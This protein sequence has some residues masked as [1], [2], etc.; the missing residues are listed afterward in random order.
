[1][2]SFHGL[3]MWGIGY[4]IYK[5]RFI[6]WHYTKPE[7][8]IIFFLA[9]LS[10]LYATL[11]Y[12][13]K[14]KAIVTNI[15]SNLKFERQ[16]VLFYYFCHAIGFYAAYKFIKDFSVG[17]GGFENFLVAMFLENQGYMIRELYE[18]INTSATQI[19]YFGW[20]AVCIT[21]YMI[22][23]KSIGKFTGILL[24]ILQFFPNLLYVDRTRPVWL[25]FCTFISYFPLNNNLSLKKII[26][27]ISLVLIGGPLLFVLLALASG[28]GWNYDDQSNIYHDLVLYF[29]GSFAYFNRIYDEIDIYNQPK[30]L[31]YP[32][33]KITSSINLTDQPPSQIL[34][35][36]SLPE[37]ANVGTFLEPFYS[38]GGILYTLIGI[39]IHALLLN[40]INYFFLKQRT[41]FFMFLSSNICFI[42]FIAFFT[43]KIASTPIWLFCFI[44][45]IYTFFEKKI[46]HV[47]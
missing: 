35:F 36:Y 16:P 11:L 21:P 39:L 13:N 45:I 14:Y 18:D 44:G 25:I 40:S 2:P 28:R 42:N 22:K 34:K 31:L 8:D 26:A 23:T 12:F 17:F 37:S 24:M 1:M 38:D 47:H 27:G 30:S 7:V 9:L 10:F 5:C 29:S 6:E 15:K 3:V 43:P 33:L 4:F 41:V 19:S 20:I 32:L 46:S